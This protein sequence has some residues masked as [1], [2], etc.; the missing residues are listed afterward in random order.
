MKRSEAQHIKASA[1]ALKLLERYGISRPDEICVED[2]AWDLGIE[3]TCEPLSGAEAYLVRIGDVGEITLSDQLVEVGSQRFAVGHEIGHWQMH[4]EISQLFF[5]T[6]DD[7][8]DYRHSDPELEANTFAS[9]LLMPK[10]MI[11]PK[12]LTGEPS[13]G[14][15]RALAE[16]FSVITIS[17]AI[18]YADL[19]REPVM[20]V[21][22]DGTNVRWWRENRTRMDGLW[23]E[24]KQPLSE[25]CVAYHQARDGSV[26]CSLVPV[27]WD[28]WFPHVPASEDEELFELTAKIDEKG[29]M[30]SVLW[31]P[32]YT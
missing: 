24:S 11:D 15:I 23:L 19:A 2:I 5:C 20:A 14:A 10:F 3:I 6:A 12:L 21:F 32:S 4:K 25:D 27:P 8:R 22:S 9:E 18:R 13:W 1:Q 26:D 16:Q 7:L 30:M 28:A 17:A 31:A 29:T